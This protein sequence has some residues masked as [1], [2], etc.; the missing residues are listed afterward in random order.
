MKKLKTLAV[1][2]GLIALIY[3]ALGNQGNLTLADNSQPLPETLFTTEELSWL[4]EHP[5][6][7]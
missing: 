4:K 2:I 1:L 5:A 3:S 7:P 6:I